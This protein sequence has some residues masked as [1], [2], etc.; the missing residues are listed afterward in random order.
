MTDLLVRSEASA[1]LCELLAL[2]FSYPDQELYRALTSGSFSAE[3]AANTAR[4]GDPA[5]LRDA[6]EQL[7]AGVRIVADACSL[8]KLESEYLELFELNRHQPPLHLNAHLYAPGQTD[9]MP[10]YRQLN[11]MYRAFGLEVKADPRV[12]SPDHLT[13][14]LEFLAYLYRL[15]GSMVRTREQDAAARVSE[16]I[17][18]FLGELV[19]IHR[20]AA[21]L[22]DR[23]AHPFYVPLAGLLQTLLVHVAEQPAAHC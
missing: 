16:G 17:E 7:L 2:G 12:E 19:W 9:P 3:A 5:P 23:C 4:L 21:L 13:L 22:Q 20:F 15:H 1:A 6:L 18:T 14:Q 10:L 8:E 11:D